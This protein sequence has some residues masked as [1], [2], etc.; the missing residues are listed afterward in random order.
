M[1]NNNFLNYY[2]QQMTL[3]QDGVHFVVF[4]YKQGNEIDGI[5]PNIVCL[6]EMFYPKQSLRV[7]DP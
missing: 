6:E 4:P 5:V 7:S 3:K 2:C 1:T